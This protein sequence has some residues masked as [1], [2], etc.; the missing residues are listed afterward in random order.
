MRVQTPWR[1]REAPFRY[2]IRPA[3]RTAVLIPGFR[4]DGLVRVFPEGWSAEAAAFAP[5]SIAG[6]LEQLDA[7]GGTVSLTHAAIVIR[8]EWEPR[9]S[10]ADRERLW[11]AFRVPVFEQVVAEDR[12]LLAAECEA[13]DGLHIESAKFAVGDHEIDRTACA[14]G[15]ST[16]RLVTPATLRRVAAYAR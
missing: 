7:V 4:A 2:P 10:D 13:H 12:T 6:T 15:R 14:C 16:P 11:Q 9:L 8:A 5:Q 1:S 3:P